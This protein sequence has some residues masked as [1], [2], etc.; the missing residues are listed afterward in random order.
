MPAS[1]GIGAGIARLFALEGAQCVLVGRNSEALQSVAQSLAIK[2]NNKDT[3]NEIASDRDINKHDFRIGDVGKR[4]FWEAIVKDVGDIDILVNAAGVTQYSPLFATKPELIEEVL[5]TNLQGT[6]WGCQI[7]GKKMLRKRGGCI[8]NVASLLGLKGGKGSTAYAA[9][10]TRALAAEMG[11][12]NIRVN[13]IVPGYIETDMTL[14]MT[15]EAR[16]QALGAIPLKRFG[17][18]QEVADAAI[19][20]ATNKYASNCVL[21]LDG[22]LSAI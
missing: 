19:F 11:P 5:R 3:A 1:T 13:V 18:V 2:F 22:G 10:L 21:N 16:A 12:L 9:R 17:G 8:I 14:A 6:I 20:L 15:S 7:V 4:N